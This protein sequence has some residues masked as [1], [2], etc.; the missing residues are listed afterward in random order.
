MQRAIDEVLGARARRGV[1]LCQAA[2]YPVCGADHTEEQE[3]RSSCDV[4]Q[5]FKSRNRETSEVALLGTKS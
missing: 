1:L 4:Q 5:D 2:R 3:N